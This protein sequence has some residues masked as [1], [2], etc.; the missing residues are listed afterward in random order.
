[1]LIPSSQSVLTGYLHRFH[2]V[3]PSSLD[4]FASQGVQQTFVKAVRLIELLPIV[5]PKRR[6]DVSPIRK[7]AE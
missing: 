3:D 1:M 2:R 4:V 5:T 6:R 7:S